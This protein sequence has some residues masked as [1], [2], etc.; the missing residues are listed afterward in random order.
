VDMLVAYLQENPGDAAL[1]PFFYNWQQY[2]YLKICY[3][4]DNEIEPEEFYQTYV[5]VT[6][7]DTGIPPWYLYYDTIMGTGNLLAL[8]DI[9]FPKEQEYR[10]I[11]SERKKQI[12]AEEKKPPVAAV[13]Y[14]A[15]EQKPWVGLDVSAVET[16]QRI[17]DKFESREIQKSFHDYTIV[18]LNN[19]GQEERLDELVQEALIGLEEAREPVPIEGSEDWRVSIVAAYEKFKI[20]KIIEAVPAAYDDY[21]MRIETGVGFPFPADNTLPFYLADARAEVI[22]GRRLAGEG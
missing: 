12:Q 11:F 10:R 9:R 16:I 8:K 7:S 22:E 2:E 21:L 13:P 1:E 6:L 14:V 17:V 18:E 5:P 20:K 15:R 4:E 3:F 19:E